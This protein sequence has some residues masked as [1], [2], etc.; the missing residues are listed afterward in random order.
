MRSRKSRGWGESR[1]PT[2]KQRRYAETLAELAGFQDI[3]AAYGAMMQAVSDVHLPENRKL[4]SRLIDWLKTNYDREIHQ[5][6]VARKYAENGWG[7]A[8]S[9][10]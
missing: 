5:S 8:P 4:Y 6:R 7:E 2:D 10:Y 3:H 9:I 1:P